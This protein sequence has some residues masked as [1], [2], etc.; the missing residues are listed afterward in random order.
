MP[1]VRIS[2]RRGRP[3]AYRRAMGETVHRAMVGTM[4]VPPLDRFQVISD[5]ARI[6]ALFGMA[7]GIRPQGVLISLIEVRRENWSFGNGIAQYAT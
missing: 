4:N 2:L 3:A 1:L 6:V 5:Y 7:P